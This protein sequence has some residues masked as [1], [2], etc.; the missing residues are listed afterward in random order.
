MPATPI[1][2]FQALDL[3]RVVVPLD[4]IRRVCKQRGRLELLDGLLHFSA[5]E[6][7]IVGFKDLRTDDWWCADHIPGRPIFPG[8]LM[9][10]GAA[11]LCTYDF[12]H[13][14]P[15]LE[16]K[17]VG[18]GGVDAVRFRGLVEPPQR[19]IWAGRPKRLRRSMFCYEAQG[20]VDRELVFEAEIIGVVI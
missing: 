7:P 3:D 14:R 16:G 1:L 10:E 5:G 6:E 2:D 18:Y 9:I 4:D 8:V 19:M 15:D 17:F 13:R 12:V 20:Y 11:Q